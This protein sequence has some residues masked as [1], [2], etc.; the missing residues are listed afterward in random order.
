[1]VSQDIEKTTL[2]Q[3]VIFPT[4]KVGYEVTKRQIVG[5]VGLVRLRV[6]GIGIASYESLQARVF[7]EQAVVE[8][9]FGHQKYCVMMLLQ[10]RVRTRRRTVQVE[11][12]AEVRIDHNIE[13]RIIESLKLERARS[14][15]SGKQTG[16]CRQ[17]H[18]YSGSMSRTS[19]DS[20]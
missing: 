2:T 9:V 16:P 8:A 14:V 18:T 20:K 17:V 1:M 12:V 19:I 11:V 6:G 10:G 4:D 13:A 15:D 7:V 3:K 5:Y